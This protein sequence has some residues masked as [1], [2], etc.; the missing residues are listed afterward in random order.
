M[1]DILGFVYVSL[2][3]E[4]VRL[5]CISYG[6]CGVVAWMFLVCCRRPCSA[7]GFRAVG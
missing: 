7:S 4:I 5:V 2:V 1:P 3:I 6:A